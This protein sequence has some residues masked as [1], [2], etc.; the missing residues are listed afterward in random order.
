MPE[1]AP[2]TMLVSYYPKAGKNVEFLALLEKHWPTLD[3]LGLVSKMAPKLWKGCD[4]RS[5]RE[6]FLELFQWKD[7]KASDI[8]HQTPEVMAVWEPMGP[9]LETMQLTKIEP[10]VFPVAPA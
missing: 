4:K 10:L 1:S 6:F 7:E 5:G 8:A 2:V 3:R 9:L